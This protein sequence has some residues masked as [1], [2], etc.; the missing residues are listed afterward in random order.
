VTIK[1]F[2]MI[3]KRV[4]ITAEEFHDHWRYPHA[5]WGCRMTTL[6]GYVQS[7]RFECDRLEGSPATFE[8]VAEAWFRTMED[9]AQFRDEPILTQFLKPDEPKFIDVNRLQFVVTHEEV[10]DEPKGEVDFA[11]P[12]SLWSPWRSPTTV[13]LLQFIAADGHRDW[14]GNDDARLGRALGALRHVRCMPS[15]SI[16]GTDPPQLGVRE[17]QWPTFSA[18][19][20]GIAE[21]PDALSTL[22]A[23]AGRGITIAASAELFIAPAA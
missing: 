16:Y 3:P 18:F 4:G 15:A 8:G 22:L 10:I 11:D 13:K 7:H 23:R 19:A 17:L 2:I 21:A 6:H 9:A 14:A 5:V 20:Q 12:A 1:T